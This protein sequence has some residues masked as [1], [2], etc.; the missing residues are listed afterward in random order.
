MSYTATHYK[1]KTASR[2]VPV[3]PAQIGAKIAEADYYLSSVKYDGHFAMMELRLTSTMK[4]PLRNKGGPQTGKWFIVHRLSLRRWA[5]GM[6][7]FDIILCDFVNIF[8]KE[9]CLNDIPF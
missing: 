1:N 6:V 8:T 2:Y 4:S 3:D 7:S 9:M 5:I